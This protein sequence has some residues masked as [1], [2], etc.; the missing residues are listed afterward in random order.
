MVISGGY[1]YVGMYQYNGAL[2]DKIDLSTF[3]HTAYLYCAGDENYASTLNVDATYLYVGCMSG[4]HSGSTP[5]RFVRVFLS[6]F[7]RK[8]TLVLGSGELNLGTAT[9]IGTDLFGGLDVTPPIVTRIDL[10]TFTETQ[11]LTLLSDDHISAGGLHAGTNSLVYDGSTY[12]YAGGGNS[13]SSKI[14]KINPYYVDSTS[15]TYT[16]PTPSYNTTGANQ[17]CLLSCQLT[18]NIGVSMAF[19]SDNSSGIWSYNNTVALSSGWANFTVT[20]PAS[21]VVGYYWIANDTSNNWN[22]SMPIQTLTTT[23]TPNPTLTINSGL[24]GITNPVAGIYTNYTL[25]STV[26][27]YETPN[28]DYSFSNW[29]VNGS[30]DGSSNPLTF[31][32]VGNTLVQPTFSWN[33]TSL[34]SMARYHLPYRTVI[35]NGYKVHFGSEWISTSGS[36]AIVTAWFINYWLNYTV[37]SPSTQQIYFD[38]DPPILVLIDDIPTSAYT[39]AS[40]LTTITVTSTNVSIL[41]TPPSLSV[42][43]NSPANGAS[44]ASLNVW[45]QY[46]PTSIGDTIQNAT[47]WTNATG[48]WAATSFTATVNNGVVNYF[49]GSFPFTETILWNVQVYNSITY[50]FAPVNYTVTVGVISLGT[51]QLT[52]YE[53]SDQWTT[54]SIHA[55]E[56]APTDTHQTTTYEITGTD[57]TATTY[58]GS[59][60]WVVE[61]SGSLWELTDGI[62]EATVI[63]PVNGSGVQIGYWDYNGSYSTQVVDALLVKVYQS[64]DGIVWNLVGSY[65]TEPEIKAYDPNTPPG[66]GLNVMFKLE[67]YTTWS[68]YYYT[69]RTATTNV[70]STFYWGHQTDCPSG[71]T[72]WYTPASPAEVQAWQLANSNLFGFIIEPYAYFIGEQLAFGFILLI[73]GLALYIRNPENGIIPIA[74]MFI[75]FGGTGGVVSSLVPGIALPIAWAFVVFGV[76]LLFYK[77]IKGKGYGEP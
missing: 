2:V 63:R 28:T 56:L 43:L 31:T 39:W 54:K 50:A 71:L 49:F 9:M 68:F 41:Y 32:I 12:L 38:L 36:N 42:V 34:A 16:L 76:A 64:Y 58:Y 55:Y 75:L 53:R 30:I 65:I 15:P 46:T 59:R 11:T 14:I 72:L 1:L 18:D 19:E 13:S 60:V 26:T 73:F 70:E 5:S 20:L 25:G 57:P 6:N 10:T 48:V 35:P 40:G 21:G 51:L 37:A 66:T 7:T 61:Y 3:T 62:P 77:V 52:L 67:P 4:G 45:F 22:V 17:P 44:Q 23:G 27:I 47:L 74:I 24:G 69:N 8:D 33:G 29:Q